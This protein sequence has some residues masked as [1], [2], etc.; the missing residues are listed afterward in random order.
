MPGHGE[1]RRH[2]SRRFQLASMNL[3]VTER[4]SGQLVTTRGH[5]GRGGVGIEAAAEEHDG[6]GHHE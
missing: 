3:P 6:S 2:A 1:R 5:D 4:E